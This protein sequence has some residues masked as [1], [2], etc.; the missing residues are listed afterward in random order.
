MAIS[1]KINR[2]LGRAAKKLG[3]MYD[4]YRPAGDLYPLSPANKLGEV[5]AAVMQDPVARD[6]VNPLDPRYVGLIDV[7]VL[8]PGD[9]LVNDLYRFV[10]VDTTAGVPAAMIA[11]N[12]DIDVFA[13]ARNKA[14]PIP[15]PGTGQ[16]LIRSLPCYI[17]QTA[18]GGRED[19]GP[20]WLA[21]KD[22]GAV[23]RLDIRW[24]VQTPPPPESVLVDQR[25]GLKYRVLAADAYTCLAQQIQ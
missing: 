19:L 10:V 7:S 15:L 25:T 14:A 18:Y 4:H 21:S 17:R 3:V 20:D 12:A 16:A 11:C 23:G 13:E 24:H 8:Q 5:K 22:P 1:D 2:G 9:Y 6:P